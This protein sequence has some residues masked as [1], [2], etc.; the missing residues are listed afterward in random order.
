[1]KAFPRPCDGDTRPSPQY[2]NTLVFNS[3]YPVLTV[4]IVGAVA[5]CGG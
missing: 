1:M 2:R 5:F 4:G 3:R